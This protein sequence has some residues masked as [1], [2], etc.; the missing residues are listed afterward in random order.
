MQAG[1]DECHGRRAGRA[2]DRTAKA[3]DDTAKA[4]VKRP[5][6]AYVEKVYENGD[7]SGLGVGT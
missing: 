1:C 3:S 5:V 7:F 4:I 6:G 2:V